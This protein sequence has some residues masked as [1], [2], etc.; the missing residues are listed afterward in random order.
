LTTQHALL[1]IAIRKVGNRYLATM[2]IAKRIRQLNHG[3]PP[4]VQRQEG[5]SYFS[6]A[7]REVAEG[8]L[9]LAPD[10]ETPVDDNNGTTEPPPP[11]SEEA[12]QM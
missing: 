5:E 3:A 10:S 7:V 4:R 11:P 2:L 9:R 8:L 12:V 1:D 6:V